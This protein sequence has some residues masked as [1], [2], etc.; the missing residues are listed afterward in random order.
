MTVSREK[1]NKIIYFIL[2]LSSAY[3]G[4]VAVLYYYLGESRLGN[5][6]FNILVFPFVAMLMH[7]A[8]QPAR[9]PFMKYAVIASSLLSLMFVLGKTL[10]IDNN[11]NNILDSAEI[12]M[13]NFMCLCGLF[14][15]LASIMCILFFYVSRIQLADWP[16]GRFFCGNKRSLF[17]L[18]GIIFICWIPCLL[19]Y[20]PGIFSYDC[21]NQTLQALGLAPFDRMQT[22]AHTF[23]FMVCMKFGMLF[24][25][26]EMALIFHSVIQMLLL[27]LS[28][29]FV[30]WYFARIGMNP[31]LRVVILAFV[32][33]SPMNALM[34]IAM[35]KDITFAVLFMPM[36]VCILDLIR[37]TERFFSS[38]WRQA[39]T[40][41]LIVAVCLFRINAAFAMIFFF[42]V[43]IIILRGYYLKILRM[44]LT[45][46]IA[47][48]LIYG[49]LYSLLGVHG[50]NGK[51]MLSV[52][53]QQIASV[54]Q[55]H[56]D[57]LSEEDIAIIADIID[58]TTVRYYYNPRY[59]DPVK[60]YFNTGNFMADIPRYAGLWSRLLVK[61]PDHYISAFLAL[62]LNYWYP[63][64]DFVDPYSERMYIESLV[65]YDFDFFP[66]EH[67]SLWLGLHD[68]YE[69]FASGET[70]AKIPVISV[71][72]NIGF[73]VWFLII[74]IIICFVRKNKRLAL[75]LW[76]ALLVW[77]TFMLGPVSNVR[78]IYYLFAAMP[79]YLAIILCSDKFAAKKSLQEIPAAE[80]HEIN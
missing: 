14:L 24:G 40:A 69:G 79:L 28:F 12:F 58:I 57:E 52:P 6:L 7:K 46:L 62:N 65:R 47:F 78:Y 3:I 1:L 72:Y 35:A 76:P 67:N 49:P 25:G 59:A 75:C 51:E 39:V 48:L 15:V 42:V 10:Y 53:I 33:L 36:L 13:L 61:Y 20:W 44:G 5:S 23:F 32:A 64:S 26:P 27:S 38:I 54:L 71:I 30:L 56:Q 66:V 21:G 77:F 60:D 29:A 2:L 68:L 43:M 11:F 74:G 9:R 70:Q 16:S 50:A 34:S 37:N 18:W 8:L 4:T 80:T 73:P 17:I 22:T 41:F 55:E 19:A 45:S 63:D 31:I